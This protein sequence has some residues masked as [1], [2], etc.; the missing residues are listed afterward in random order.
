MLQRVIM[1]EV[2]EVK[3]YVDFLKKKMQNK[4]LKELNI[5]N[6][7]YKKH[8]PFPLYKELVKELPLKVLDVKNKGK[9]MYIILEK[10]FIIFSTLG[11]SGGW[12]YL[13]NKS[14]KYKFPLLVDYLGDYDIKKYKKNALNHLNVEFKLEKGSIYY[15]DVLS[16]GTLKV[17]NN[18]LNLEKKLKSLA[19]DIMDLDIT[20]DIFK[21]QITKKNNL[22]KPI[23]NILM[24]QKVISGIGNYLRADILWLSG[25]YPFC[26]VK[27]LKEK[28]LKSIYYNSI[29]LTWG[30]YNFTEAVRLKLIDPKSKMPKDYGRNFFIYKQDYDIYGN[31]VLKEE[32]YEGSQKRFIYFV[33]KIQKA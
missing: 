6:G 18:N 1:P 16:F 28:E 9:F 8:G 19:Y 5:I 15:F 11:L 12:I 20:Y 4:E 24:N 10:N 14:S 13:S 23:G 7:R 2:I 26:K 21:D 31:K 17:V 29:L 27:D 25:V 30:E 32:L 33:K 22:D 3:K